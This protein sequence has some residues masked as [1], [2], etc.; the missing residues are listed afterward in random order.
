MHYEDLFC[1][2]KIKPISM[3]YLYNDKEWEEFIEE[4]VSVKETHYEEVEVF[5]GSGDKGRDIVAYINKHKPN[6]KWDC[7][8]C[9]FYDKPLS[10]S[11][12][13]VEFG[14]IIYYTFKKDYPVP[15]KYYFVAPKGVGPK[16]TD[17][18]NNPAKLKSILSDVWATHCQKKIT[19]NEE[20]IL[21][22]DFLDYYENFDFKIFDRVLVKK[23]I[24]EHKA[25]E[26][27]AN[28]FSIKLPS[29]GKTPEIPK[30]ISKKELI[31]TEQL[32]KAYNT[33]E[34]KNKFT[35][36]SDFTNVKPY[37]GHFKRAR[38]SFHTAEQLFRFSRDNLG[39]EYFLKLQ[40]DI[41]LN[42][43]DISEQKESNKFDIVKNVEKNAMNT[44]FG[45]NP[46]QS[47]C[48]LED[49]KGICHR[50]VNEGKII[51]VE[52]DE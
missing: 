33:D 47:R 7:Y 37:N 14:K 26:N 30:E 39:E 9:K 51:W 44:I 42:I 20:V 11:E 1:G 8:Q 19:E 4:W 22:G 36:I 5:G 41:Y 27:H 13:W 24:E 29:R 46:L 12:V 6:Y 52:K 35:C 18:L 21:S 40:K 3:V 50:L 43:I 23:I 16:L 2:P 49:K 45:S 10:P 31:Y 32:R 34:E 38:E 15:K 25:H 48:E 17:L 28:R